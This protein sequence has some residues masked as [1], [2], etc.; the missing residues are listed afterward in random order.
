MS[1][2]SRHGQPNQKC[3]CRNGCSSQRLCWYAQE[4]QQ[5]P[6]LFKPLGK[7]IIGAGEAITS[8]QALKERQG[9]ATIDP[10]LAT[11]NKPLK[12]KRDTDLG[13]P[14]AVEGP[15]HHSLHRVGDVS[16]SEEL[17][18]PVVVGTPHQDDVMLAR[19]ARYARL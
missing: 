15:K 12:V 8:D 19:P 11:T 10:T 1:R 6:I 3:Y 4:S 18:K 5:S 16:S 7:T 9:G 17:E 14:S 2:Y 13:V